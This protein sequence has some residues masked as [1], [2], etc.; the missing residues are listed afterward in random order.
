MSK[1]YKTLAEIAPE[2]AGTPS[3]NA[4][5]A[6]CRNGIKASNGERVRLA[7]IR[8][9]GR[10]MTSHEDVEAFFKELNAA[11]VAHF[12]ARDEPGMKTAQAA[13]VRTPAQRSK[14]VEAAHKR[15][16]GMGL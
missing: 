1:E 11:D 12:A 5:W 15:L 9:G 2:I 4:V 13:P 3:S 6:W 10:L 8:S 7:H 14:D 16:S